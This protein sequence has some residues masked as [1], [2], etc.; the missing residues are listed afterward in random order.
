MTSLISPVIL[1]WVKARL[2]E[3]A[4]DRA[5]VRARLAQ[6]KT[7]VDGTL[8]ASK[9]D[10]LFGIRR[11]IILLEDKPKPWSNATKTAI[12]LAKE[13]LVNLQGVIENRYAAERAAGEH[14]RE[15]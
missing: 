4:E 10:Q 12:A 3:A 13:R 7:L 11:E 6:I 9:E 2:D 14:V 8:T 1:L 15:K 5:D